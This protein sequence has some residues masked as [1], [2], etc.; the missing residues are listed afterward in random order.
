LRGNGA[1]ALADLAEAERLGGG[2]YEI[3]RAL[4]GIVMGDSAPARA[5]WSRLLARPDSAYASLFWAAR[6]GAGLGLWSETLAV[7]ER[8]PRGYRYL[9]T[10]RASTVWSLLHDPIFARLSGE[11]RF[12][13]LMEEVRPRT[14]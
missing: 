2:P 14:R 4:A 12:A 13:R 3:E 11:P 7:L 10:T 9:P 6:L 1:G 5:H 8:L